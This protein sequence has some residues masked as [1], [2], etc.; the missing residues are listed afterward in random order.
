MI[1]IEFSL[2]TQPDSH[3]HGRLTA[4]SQAQPEPAAVCEIQG[5]WHCHGTRQHSALGVT[6][7]TL[8]LF[9][10]ALSLIKASFPNNKAVQ[11][12]RG[13]ICFLFFSQKSPGNCLPRAYSRGEEPSQGH[14]L[15]AAEELTGTGTQLWAAMV[16][17][18]LV[19]KQQGHR[20]FFHCSKH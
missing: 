8:L 17:C 6:L 11:L 18:S 14:V 15:H 13:A 10:T 5:Q 4:Q 9:K 1:K 2:I 7:D 19:L 16:H 20:R 3:H 12:Q